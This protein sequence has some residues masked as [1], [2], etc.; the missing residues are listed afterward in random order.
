MVAC[1]FY[2]CIF[3]KENLFIVWGIPM[4][5]YPPSS[6]LMELPWQKNPINGFVW[7]IGLQI[8]TINKIHIHMYLENE[9]NHNV[10]I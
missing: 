10:Y 9:Q 3:F 6:I 4:G 7:W 2:K 8:T 5:T 1:P